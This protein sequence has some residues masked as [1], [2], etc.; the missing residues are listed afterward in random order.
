MTVCPARGHFLVTVIVW[1]GLLKFMAKLGI[2][3]MGG[4][5]MKYFAEHL[6]KAFTERRKDELVGNRKRPVPCCPL[7][8][9]LFCCWHIADKFTLIRIR[10]DLTQYSREPVRSTIFSCVVMQIKKEGQM[11]ND[12]TLSALAHKVILKS[13]FVL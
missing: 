6:G 7:T 3:F 4:S 12:Q 13:T 1:P 8:F 2:A 11:S 10:I 5:E 9:L